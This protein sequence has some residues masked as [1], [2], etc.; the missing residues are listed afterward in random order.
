MGDVCSVIDFIC[1]SCQE[2][3]FGGGRRLSWK[4]CRSLCWQTDV[5]KY[6]STGEKL[7]LHRDSIHVSLKARKRPSGEVITQEAPLQG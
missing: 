1:P 2:T 4:F 5:A 6:H 3:D 7:M